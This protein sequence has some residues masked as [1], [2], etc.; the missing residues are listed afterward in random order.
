[1]FSITSCKYIFKCNTK[2]N[3]KYKNVRLVVYRYTYTYSKD[4]WPSWPLAGLIRVRTSH[5]LI[6]VEG[7]A[8]SAGKS[9]PL[10]GHFH[11]LSLSCSIC[12]SF[13]NKTPLKP[14]VSSPPFPG[15]DPWLQIKRCW[16]SLWLWLNTNRW[17][18]T[19]GHCSTRP[20]PRHPQRAKSQST[21]TTILRLLSLTPSTTWLVLV[22]LL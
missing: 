11:Q 12:S 16:F 5:S 19:G 20:N 22:S 4:P 3:T 9:T 21:K 1:M 17:V 18:W 6:R 13:E 14:V 10:P 2:N 7:P 8:V 15:W